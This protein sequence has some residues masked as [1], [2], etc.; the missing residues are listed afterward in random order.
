MEGI[1]AGI[2]AETWVKAMGYFKDSPSVDDRLVKAYMDCLTVHAEYL[3]TTYKHFQ[4]KSNWGVIENRGLMEI[5]LA[6]PISDWTR[7]YLDAALMRLS[8]EIEVQIADDGVH[9][10]QSPMYHNEV[11]HCY[12]EVMRLAKRYGIKLSRKRMEKVRQMAY[13]NAA[14]KKPNHCQ[15]MQGDSDETDIRDLLT[16]SACCLQTRY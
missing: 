6:L 13:A 9:W 8:E 7:E 3:M 14:W 10:E 15:P 4:I 1:E 12:L 5:A 11:F 2:R 16:Q